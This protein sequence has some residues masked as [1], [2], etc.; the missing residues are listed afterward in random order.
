MKNIYYNRPIITS[1]FDTMFRN[2]LIFLLM[3]YKCSCSNIQLENLKEPDIVEHLIIDGF[4]YILL[5]VGK[6]SPC[7][8]ST[9]ERYDL[10]NIKKNLI[11]RGKLLYDHHTYKSI[12]PDPPMQLVKY[13]GSRE[14]SVFIMQVSTE[15]EFDLINLVRNFNMKGYIVVIIEEESIFPVLKEWILKQQ[16]FNIY[17]LRKSTFYS[18]YFMYEVCAFCNA[19]KHVIKLHNIWTPIGFRKELRYVSS[20]KK[21]FNGA[22]LRVGTNILPTS[23]LPIK[24]PTGQI[25]FIGADYWFFKTIGKTLKFN[26]IVTFPQDG[27]ACYGQI[28]KNI[29][30]S[31]KGAEVY[32]NLK[33]VGYCKLLKE[34][35]VDLAGFPYFLSPYAMDY[36]H[37]SPVYLQV[38]RN[39]VSA[40]L[41]PIKQGSSIFESL[42]LSVILLGLASIFCIA[43]C[44]WVIQYLQIGSNAYFSDAFFDTISLLF[45]EGIIIRRVNTHVF[46]ISGIWMVS[47]FFVIS[48]IFGEMTSVATGPMKAPIVINSIEDMKIHGYSWITYKAFAYGWIL[49]HN[50]PD[51]AKRKKELGMAE[52]LQY[53][54]SRP[55]DYVF[56]IQRF[57]I[58][59]IIRI[60]FWNGKDENPFHI[61]PPVQG[62]P[63]DRIIFLL[64]QDAP[65]RKNIDKVVMHM[66][67]AHLLEGR[68]TPDTN[69]ILAKQSKLKYDP[70]KEESES[71]IVYTSDQLKPT[72]IL[73]SCI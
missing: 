48:N 69:A 63:A 40:K 56:Y 60:Y 23:V 22:S 10:M 59:P 73:I 32:N 67:A 11:D 31:L 28:N 27:L 6:T 42:Q 55:R 53:V 18:L 39:L 13:A 1:D 44:M 36:F 20:F 25:I 70:S 15:A 17:I 49:E 65:Y 38:R 50:L 66:I 3:L 64:R 47:C 2:I 35:K 12:K 45:L 7:T 14:N 4:H 61:S 43:V 9:C 29:S 5:D 46:I 71:E 34:K 52:A 54:L 58:V 30:R 24:T 62:E 19:G 68:F 21:Y 33:S 72:V 16:L 26:P 8:Y 57:P 41:P 37:P 51:Q